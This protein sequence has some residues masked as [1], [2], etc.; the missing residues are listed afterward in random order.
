MLRNNGYNEADYTGCKMDYLHFFSRVWQLIA[1]CLKLFQ[2]RVIW[3]SVI[4]CGH[5]IL[6][7]HPWR[8]AGSWYILHVSVLYFPLIETYWS[9]YWPSRAFY[10]PLFYALNPSLHRSQHPVWSWSWSRPSS[11]ISCGANQMWSQCMWSLY[12]S[13]LSLSGEGVG[14]SRFWQEND[15]RIDEWHGWRLTNESQWRI[16]WMTNNECYFF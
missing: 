1:Y 7:E 13:L 8:K 10:S 14:K 11:S 6:P 2:R 16:R 15:R 9:S 12:F 5:S 4:S 3:W